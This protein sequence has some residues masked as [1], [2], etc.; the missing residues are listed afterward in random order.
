MSYYDWWEKWMDRK[1]RY[2]KTDQ[3]F[4]DEG[5]FNAKSVG[6]GLPPIFQQSTFSFQSVE[7]GRSRFLGVSPSGEKPFARVYTRLGNPTTE[8]LEKIMFQLECQHIIDNALAADEKEPTIGVLITSSGMGAIST[9][10]LS[11]LSSGDEVIVGTVYGC[12]DSL[13]RH[14]DEK[15]GVKAHFIDTTDLDEV[16]ATLKDNPRIRAIYVETPENPTLKLNDIRGLSSLTEKYEIPLIVDN[17][18]CSPYLQQPY[19]LG[20]DIV[21][22]SMTK[23]VNGHSTS[24]AGILMGPWEFMLNDA[25]VFYKDLGATPSPFDSWLN[26]QNVQ[27][28]AVRQKHQCTSAEKIARFLDTHPMVSRT[29]YPFLSSHP[30]HELAKTQMRMGGAMISFELKGGYDAAVKLMNYFAR[31][32]TPMELAVSLGSVITYIQHPASMTHGG[33]PEDEKKRMGITEELVRISV[34]LEGTTVLINALEE[35]IRLAHA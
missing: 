20:A 10:I 18:F 21:L 23:Y 5:L 33:V 6:T 14:L 19:R 26:A 4:M 15:Y 16:A 12:T 3:A 13:F 24:I 9:C 7:D 25:F 8:Y 35:G 29:I 17:T 11:L 30:Q 22:H 34:G 32:D 1:H 27:D 31:H 28:L 2:A